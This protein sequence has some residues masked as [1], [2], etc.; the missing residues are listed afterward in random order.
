MK[1]TYLLY[2]EVIFYVIFQDFL[3]YKI[4]ALLRLKLCSNI[5]LI[6]FLFFLNSHF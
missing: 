3:T 4:K 6:C 2:Y 5:F 1:D